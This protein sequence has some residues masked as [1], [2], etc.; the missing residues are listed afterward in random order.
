MYAVWLAAWWTG[1]DF[2]YGGVVPVVCGE[3]E[4]EGE[5]ER[6]NPRIP[7]AVVGTTKGY[8]MSSKAL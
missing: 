4:R 1:N 8:C 6:A 7:H 5:R 3:R 2:W